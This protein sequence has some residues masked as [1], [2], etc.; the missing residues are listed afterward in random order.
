MVALS[1]LIAKIR[2]HL[3]VCYCWSPE[4]TNES[5]FLI[6]DALRPSY[7]IYNRNQFKLVAGFTE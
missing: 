4:P 1:L 5:L 3:S 6:H 7:P 2:L